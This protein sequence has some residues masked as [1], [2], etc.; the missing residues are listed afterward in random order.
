MAG[1]STPVAG[2]GISVLREGLTPGS[3]GPVRA[4]MSSNAAITNY[5]DINSKIG[6]VQSSGLIVTGDAVHITGPATRLRG[7]R[8][9][10]IQNL[11]AGA[12]FIGDSSV[13]T[14]D[15]LSIPSGDLLS[16]NVLD[17]GDIFAISDGT[18]DLR[19]LELK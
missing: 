14:S 19:I 10:I 12:A 4:L 7:R 8:Q 5:E 16:L 15:G 3:R 6:I 2:S 1:R 9:I 13:T 17:F 18:S 11:G